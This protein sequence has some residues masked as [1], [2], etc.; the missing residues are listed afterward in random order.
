M[1][2]ELAER[3]AGLVLA[4]RKTSRV[5]V[6]L[7]IKETAHEQVRELVAKGPPFD[8][9]TS[10][11]DGHHV[12]LTD[13]EVIFIF[14]ASDPSVLWRLAANL[15]L[16]EAAESW[17]QHAAGPARIAED[18]FSWTRSGLDEG[19]FFTATP[20]PGDSE[21]GDVYPP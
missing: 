14:E 3:L 2:S 21:G 10:G 16:L 18:A 7:P 12:S 20:G 15:E 4:R 11:L 5:V 17:R 9:E 19:L 8:L 6:V 1:V 13:R